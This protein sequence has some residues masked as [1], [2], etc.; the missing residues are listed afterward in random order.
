MF[1]LII[2]WVYFAFD[3][4][5]PDDATGL[6]GVSRMKIANQIEC[7]MLSMLCLSVRTNNSMMPISVAANLYFCEYVPMG[8]DLL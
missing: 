4:R 3:F 5:K 6:F 1:G 8:I 7:R 2:P